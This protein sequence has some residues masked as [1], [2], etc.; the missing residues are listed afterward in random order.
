MGYI[1]FGV[2]RESRPMLFYIGSGILFVLSQL[3]YFLL[4]KV[5]CRV[6]PLSFHPLSSSL[7]CP[8]AFEQDRRFFHCYIAGDCIRICTVSGMEKYHRRFAFPCTCL[9]FDNLF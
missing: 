7:T 1:V 9:D 3:D 6:R 4:S 8:I 2:L 5:I